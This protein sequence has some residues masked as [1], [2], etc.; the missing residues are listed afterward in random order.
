MSVLTT[1]QLT[2]CDLKD[3]YSVHI[4]TEYIGLTCNN[5]GK[6]TEQKD[7]AVQ[8]YAAAGSMRVGASCTVYGLPSGITVYSKTNSSA[9]NNGSIVFRVAKDSNLGDNLTS[10][11]KIVFT[12]LDDEK[13]TFEKYIT[14]V[15]SMDGS[16]VNF[17]IYSV[18]GFEFGDSLS[19]IILK[20]AAFRGS[21]Q[22]TSGASYKWMWWNDGLDNPDYEIISGKESSELEVKINDLY[23]FK[24]IKC[25]MT[26]DNV[27]YEDHVS[28][29]QKTDAY[30]AI[31]RFFNGSNMILNNAD[32]TIL[33]VDLYKNNELV[34]TVHTNDVCIKNEGNYNTLEG[35]KINTNYNET[36][37]NGDK[38]YFVCQNTYDGIVEYNVVLG[39]YENEQ[40][41][42]I[43]SNYTYSNN[44]FPHTT[45][46]IIYVPKEKISRSLNI[47]FTIKDNNNSIVAVTSATVLD[48]N[49]PIIGE[50]P[51]IPKEGQL[52]LDTSSNLL[53]MWDGEKWVNSGY[54]NGNVVYTSKPT[55]YSDGDLWILGT[56]EECKVYGEDGEYTVYKEGSLLKAT[57]SSDNFDEHDWQDVD[58]VSSG[59]IKN[60]K[61]SFTWND[62]GIQIAKKVTNS[63]GDVSYPFYVHIDSEKMGFHSVSYNPDGSSNDDI[64]VV[65]IGNN[66][67]TI[68]NAKFEG[69]NGTQF[70]N[71]VIFNKQINIINSSSSFIW[72]IEESNGSLTLSIG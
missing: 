15:K 56:R 17:Q 19:S 37:N 4:D 11:V 12:T 59:I 39:I 27:N 3:S 22:I 69:S 40:W 60:V 5:D 45:S 64:E 10:S 53:K 21:T 8:Y 36:S 57:K 2:F 33:Y 14:F 9:S 23:A 61:E 1:S 68:Q 32:Y 62:D 58:A 18:D 35:T 55:S 49:D 63:N 38:M 13:F 52:W 48:L 71:N 25:I 44:L 54:Q 50:E 41:N 29:T 70:N 24:D 51:S 46:N 34:D 65:H 6:V 7:I 20:T 31:P 72:K 43:E 42:L 16:S 47:N 28:L 67:A 30:M 26:Y 66:S